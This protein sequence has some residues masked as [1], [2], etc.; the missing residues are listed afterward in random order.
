MM[1]RTRVVVV[2]LTVLLVGPLGNVSMS[3]RA[4]QESSQGFPEG[5]SIEELKSSE[6]GDVPG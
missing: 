6:I 4:L 5:I 3:A 2:L 1:F